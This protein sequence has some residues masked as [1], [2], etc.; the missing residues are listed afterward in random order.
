MYPEHEKLEA[1]RDQSQ[2][3]GEF[4]EWLSSQG[5]HL[6]KWHSHATGWDESVPLFMRIEDILAQYFDIDQNRLED[7]KQE[8]LDSLRK[9]QG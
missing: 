9:V 2:I 3:I 4:L 8:I 6:A 7:E 1:I 5:I